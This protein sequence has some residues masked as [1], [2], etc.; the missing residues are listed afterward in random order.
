MNMNKSLRHSMLPLLLGLVGWLVGASL[1]AA[2]ATSNVII[3][4]F[5]FLPSTVTINVND[6]V[7]WTWASG[8]TPHSTTATTNSTELWDSGLH[9]TPFSFG[10]T[11]AKG[12]SFP[13]FCT[14]HPFML[15]SVTVQGGN[16]P[17]TASLSAPADGSTFAAPWTGT[18]QASVADSDGTVTKV[19]FFANTTSLGVVNNPGP[20]P[21]ITVTNLATG[22]YTLTAVATDDGGGVTTSPGVAITVVEPGPISVSAPQRLSPTAFQFTYSAT[23][24]LSYVIQRSA[25][26]SGFTPIATNPATLSSETFTDND[27]IAAVNFYQVKLAPNR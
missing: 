5:A 24:G 19:E 16:V 2:A 7:V 9:G 4:N 1:P 14:L 15:G 10:H 17:P 11:F 25:N 6:Q 13:Y 20:T 23:P 27:A 26:L 3:T 12:G 21:S 22:N 18:V 8:I